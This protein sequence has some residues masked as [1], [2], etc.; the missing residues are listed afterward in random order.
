MFNQSDQGQINTRS[1]FFK[2]NQPLRGT[3]YGQK[4]LSYLTPSTWNNLPNNRK[5]LNNLN[6]FKH[7]VKKYYLSQLR[8]KDK[9]IYSYA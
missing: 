8:D 6:T 5:S 9:N 4:S 1:S 7:G 3:S 2:L